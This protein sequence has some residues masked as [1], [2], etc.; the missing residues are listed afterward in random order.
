MIAVLVVL[1]VIVAR[2]TARS[3]RQI[4][5]DYQRG[6]RFQGGKPQ[7]IL[8]P[9]CHRFQPAN[10]QIIVV[11]L[12]DQPVIVERFAYADSTGVNAL[13]SISAAVRV[14]DVH[15]ASTQYRDHVNEAIVALREALRQ[16][17]SASRAAEARRERRR[18][19]QELKTQ[20][21]IELEK[22]GL[23]LASLEIT[24]VSTPATG[25]AA[26]SSGVQ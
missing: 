10:E 21:A 9:G 4:I 14:A 3:Q 15:R 16:H 11:D 20:A 18:Y 5:L 2:L 23:A 17:L 8:G 24:E 25:L 19:E 7:A 22:L 1:L 12:R 13:V 26:G 6:I